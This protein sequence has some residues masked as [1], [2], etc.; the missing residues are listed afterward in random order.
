MRVLFLFDFELID[1]DVLFG[2]DG[3]PVGVEVFEEIGILYDLLIGQR[4][5]QTPY[6][7]FVV[8]IFP[9]FEFLSDFF[10][11]YFNISHMLNDLGR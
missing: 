3:W 4:N 5:L 8:E 10:I 11:P 7:I 1:F 6:C 2:L 9:Y